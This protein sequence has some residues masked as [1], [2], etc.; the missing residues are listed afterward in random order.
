M[1]QWSGWGKWCGG[2]GKCGKVEASAVV[3]G[4]QGSVVVKQQ[5]EQQGR[6][7]AEH[8]AVREGGLEQ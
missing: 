5:V 6:D 7:G 3:E 8:G 4:G 1:V 2:G